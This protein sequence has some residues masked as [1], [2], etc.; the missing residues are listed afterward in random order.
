MQEHMA[1]SW[2]KLE[3]DFMFESET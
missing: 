3:L 2:D 1:K